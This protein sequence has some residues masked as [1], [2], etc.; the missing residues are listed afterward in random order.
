MNKRIDNMDL[1]ECVR[2]WGLI[3]KGNQTHKRKP[4]RWIPDE[5]GNVITP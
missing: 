4:I 5:F 3:I 1:E 2:L